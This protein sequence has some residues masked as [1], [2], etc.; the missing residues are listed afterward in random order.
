[1]LVCGRL[2][3]VLYKKYP[4]PFRDCALIGI[5]V[6]CRCG[7][8][9]MVRASDSSSGVSDQQSMGSSPCCGTCVLEQDAFLYLLC[10]LDRTLSRFVPCARIDMPKN[11]EHFTWKSR[12]NL[13]VAVSTF[14]H[15]Q[16][17]E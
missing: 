4:N 7:V 12:V 16:F 1:M 13:G 3:F 17:S 8:V 6:V 5:L 14:R 9:N 10:P 2:Y 15:V 11:Q